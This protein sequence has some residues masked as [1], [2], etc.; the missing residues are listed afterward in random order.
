MTNLLNIF[1]DLLLLFLLLDLFVLLSLGLFVMIRE[2]VKDI[3]PK[4][5]KVNKIKGD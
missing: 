5:V 1:C 4:K 2:F 3:R